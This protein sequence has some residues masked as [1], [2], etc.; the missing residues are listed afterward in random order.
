MC[1]GLFGM[2]YGYTRWIFFFIK[3]IVCFK[4]TNHSVESCRTTVSVDLQK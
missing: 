1:G 4:I 2:L 3:M